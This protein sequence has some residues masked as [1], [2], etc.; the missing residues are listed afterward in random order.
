MEGDPAVCCKLLEFSV[1][2]LGSVA[3]LTELGL[4]LVSQVRYPNMCG[5]ISALLSGLSLWQCPVCLVSSIKHYRVRSATRPVQALPAILPPDGHVH[6]QRADGKHTAL[7][8]SPA[9][10]DVKLNRIRGSASSSEIR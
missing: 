5:T 6:L 8:D 1:P 3:Y 7:I 9:A 4:A 10:C 2:C